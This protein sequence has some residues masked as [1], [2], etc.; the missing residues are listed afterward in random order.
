M[1]WRDRRQAGRKW[2]NI[3]LT[4]FKDLYRQAKHKVSKLVH[5]AKCQYYTERT[6]VASSCNVLHQIFNTLSNGHPPRI[7]SAIYASADLP[8]LLIKHFTNKVEKIRAIIASEPV[9]STLASVEYHGMQPVG[10]SRRPTN[11]TAI[12]KCCLTVSRSTEKRHGV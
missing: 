5:T 6:A 8:S 1:A 3:K 7:L 11:P 9:T 2:R 4:I 10:F 12:T